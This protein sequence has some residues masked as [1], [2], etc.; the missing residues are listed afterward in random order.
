V[1]KGHP[2]LSRL[3]TDDD[4]LRQIES[5]PED[6]EDKAGVFSG[7]HAIN[8]F[9]GERLPVY[10]AN[11]V[12]MEYGTGA[13]MAVP[14][15]DQRDFEFAGKYGLPVR[16]V[17]RRPD[18]D[19][20]PGEALDEAYE[21]DG[22]LVESGEF[23]GLSSEEARERIADLAE[24]KGIGCRRVNYKLR[25]WGISRQR[26]WGTPIPVIYC[27][28]CGIVPV[29]EADL[30]VILPENVKLQGKGASPLAELEEFVRVPCPRCGKDARRETDTMDTF[31]D[32]SWYF[33]RYCSPAVK[34]SPIDS[35]AASYWMPV[36]QY[37]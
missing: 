28:D 27:E 22:I 19:A 29:P 36:D 32:S 20:A 9:T 26:Y 33:L 31:V 3:V 23:T 8:P 10:A 7:I 30:P 4:I 12:L 6:P 2:V 21:E 5:M 14:A 11:F 34:E 1:A 25:D 35:G 16:T 37:I 24:A 18:A 15:H 13:I 17:I